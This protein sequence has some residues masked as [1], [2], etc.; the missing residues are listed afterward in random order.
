MQPAELAAA[1]AVPDC[2]AH[3]LDA[4]F[5]VGPVKPGGMGAAPLGF[6]DLA[7][8]SA[9]VGIDLTPWEARTIVAL[10]RLYLVEYENA[11]EGGPAPTD[12]G[13]TP[14]Q[15]QEVAQGLAAMLRR[16]AKRKK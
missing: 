14:E 8:W 12:E 7:D 9:L 5:E 3:I 15:K 1:P 6:S 10:S 13:P 16:N 2:A 11:R 4:L